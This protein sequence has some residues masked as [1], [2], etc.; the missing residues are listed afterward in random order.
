MVQ[1]RLCFNNLDA[2]TVLNDSK[3]GKKLEIAFCESC[4]LV[5]Q[6]NIPTSDELKIY[7]SHTYRKEYKKSYQPKTKHVFRAAKAA[8]D[9]LEM[10]LRHV[11]NPSELS[12][13]DIGAGG[14]EFVYLASRV[15]FM[16]SGVEP[17]LGYSEY[18]RDQYGVQ[19]SS[20]TLDELPE[21]SS[22]V[23]TLFHVLEHLAKPEE[24]MK[25]I[26]QTLNTDGF[27][28]IE[29]PNILQNDASPHN[30]Y[31]KAHLYYFSLDTLKAVASKYFEVIEICDQGNL[32]A[33]FRKRKTPLLETQLP[34][35]TSVN[36]AKRRLSEK[37]WMEYL[38]DGGGIY[39]PFKRIK[40]LF[41]EKNL[42]YPTHK[43]VLDAM[44]NPKRRS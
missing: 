42:R 33:I 27:L 37:G 12:L 10:L 44:P 35:E 7:Y 41:I 31:F 18:A 34:D 15:G 20:T 24:T 38:F 39:K 8:I 19:V 36:W 9:R 28:F 43:A 2:F 23:V 3:S 32:K 21:Q 17:N 6:K 4:G 16:A 22:D 25:R 29:V 1:C 40:Q 30:I 26:Y 5:Q 11:K 14:G 13:L